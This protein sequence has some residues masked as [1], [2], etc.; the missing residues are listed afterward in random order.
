MIFWR[1]VNGLIIRGEGK[2][3]SKSKISKKNQF[4]IVICFS[5]NYPALIKKFL[6]GVKIPL[7]TLPKICLIPWNFWPWKIHKRANPYL[8]WKNSF[9]RK[10]SPSTLFLPQFSFV[11][12]EVSFGE[13]LFSWYAEYD[14]VFLKSVTIF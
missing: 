1:E 5:L 9:F 12:W 6:R 10:N 14:D 3:E 13:C 11:F 2:E 7:I 8:I 4:S